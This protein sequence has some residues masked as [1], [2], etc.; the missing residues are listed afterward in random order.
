MSYQ[1]GDVLMVRPQNLPENV[2][3][4][5]ELLTGEDAKLAGSK[6]SRGT[7]FKVTQ[8]DPDMAVPEQLEHPQ[9]LINLATHY[10]DLNVSNMVDW[11]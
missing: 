1:P 3:L 9:S 10:W 6:L 7:V 8:N 11:W 2:E 4:L 5:M